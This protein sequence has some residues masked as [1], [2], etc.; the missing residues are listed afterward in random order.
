M[1]NNYTGLEAS[2][3]G[4]K[5]PAQTYLDLAGVMFVAIDADQKVTLINQKGCQILG[6]AKE[7]ILGKNWFDTFIPEKIREEVRTGFF[8]LLGGVTEVMEYMENPILLAGGEER[9]ISWHNTIMKDEAGRITGTLSSGEDITDRRKAESALEDERIKFQA[10]SD[11]APFGMALVANNGIFSYINPKFKE[12]FGYDLAD[13]PDGKTWF[14]KAFPDREYRRYV[15][16]TWLADLKA[17]EEDG[18]GQFEKQILRVV[19]KDESEKM[20][21]FL[22]VHLGTGDFMMTCEDVTEL[23]ER[24]KALL[25]SEQKFRDLAEKSLVGIYLIQEGLFKYVNAQFARIHDCTPEEIIDKVHSQVFIHPDDLA[26][27][28]ENVNQKFT[29]GV[30]SLSYRFRSIT[31]EKRV[32]DVEIFIARTVYKG[33]S[34]FIGTLLDITDNVRIQEDLVRAKVQAEEASRAKSEFLANMSHEIRTPLNGVIGMA[35]LLLDTDLT[36]E[37]RDYAETINYSGNTLLAVVNDILD[38]SKVEAGKLDL[39]IIDFD[40][41]TSVE[42]VVDMLSLRAHEKGLECVFMVNPEVP[43]YVRGDPGRLRQILMNLVNNAVKFTDKGEIVV[44]ATLEE[45]TEIHVRVLFSVVDTGIGIP[46]HRLDRL[47]KSFSQVDASTTRKY[48]GT[49]LGLAIS[50]HLAEMMGGRIGVESKEGIGS[51]FWFTVTLEKQPTIPESRLHTTESIRGK[52][53]LV[54]DDNYTNQRVLT[55][56]LRPTDCRLAMASSATEALQMLWQAVSEN[57]PYD[58]VIIDMLMPIMDGETLGRIIKGDLKLKETILIMLTS[59]GRRG[60]A[61]RSKDIG[62]A[63]YLT[64]PI[65]PKQLY[66][67]LAALLYDRQEMKKKESAPFITKHLIREEVKQ[68]IRILVAE[69]NTTNQKVA[70]RILEKLGYRADVAANGKEAVR[71]FDL[72]PYNLILMDV[73][74]PE[75]DGFEATAMIRTKERALGTHIPIVAM[76][77][78]ALKGDRERCLEAGMDDYVSKP[79]QPKE[80]AEVLERQ[81]EALL[82]GEAH[83]ASGPSPAEEAVEIFGRK[84]LLDRLDGDEELVQGIIAVFMEDLP[85]LKGRLEKALLEK[86]A[87]T[88]ER[89]AHTLKGAAANVEAGAL[90]AVALEIEKAGKEGRLEEAESLLPKLT[91]EVE[92]LKEVLKK[93]GLA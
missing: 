46:P 29:T 7:E 53:L 80:L 42:E 68:R 41:R 81:L 6:L 30:E 3:N 77:A 45:E 87:T 33:K 72:L 85:Q 48:G 15:T 64:K 40:L 36:D 79:I 63:A 49:G 51:K 69:D 67:C 34:A 2:L 26:Q 24:E 18:S 56:Y 50:K 20:I 61:A 55:A 13:I 73:Q 22:S 71:A 76:T 37:Q 89:Q 9:I 62:F 17:A 14:R 5:N 75:M 32:I 4:G 38:F 84:A 11:K 27:F 39:E 19:C 93:E 65:K 25:E 54:V 35:G 59:A 78:H 52:R 44:Y 43:S 10:L 91:A 70:L 21:S 16:G 90:K 31:K 60:D 23:K 47:F 58:L 1:K 88:L 86:D 83:P 8:S 57:D 28:N 92:R 74:M 82:P 66:E 12:L